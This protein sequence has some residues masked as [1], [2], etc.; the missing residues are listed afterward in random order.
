MFNRDGKDDNNY[1]VEN[2]EFIK[3]YSPT[4]GSLIEKEYNRQKNN[5]EL[6]ASENYCSEAVLAACGSCLSWKYA[7]G[8]PYVRTSG[9]KGRYYGGT[10]FV[11]ELEEYCCNK[12]REVFHTDYHVNVQPHSGSQANFAGY[13]ALINP[14]DTILSLSLD[15]GGHL[16]HGSSVNFS[17]KLYNVIF[18]DVDDKGYIDMEDVRK[19]ALEYK[20]QLIMTG[21]SAY[22]RIID[23]KAFADIAKEVGCYFMVDM[24]HIA[25]LV[26]A[27]EHPSPFGYADIVTTTTHKTLRGPRGGLVFGKQE[28]AKKIDSA[29]FPYAQGGPLEHI[30]AGKAVCAEEALKPEFKEYAHQV[31]LNCAA[32]CDEFIKLGYKVVTGGTD[33]HVFLLDLSEFPFSGRDLQERCDENGITLNKNAIPNDQR[34][35][36]QTSGVRIGTAPMTTRGYKEDDFREVARRIDKIVKEL[37]KEKEAEAK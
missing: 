7:E 25:G 34:S 28:F 13:K 10:E 26:A 14:G 21:A 23:F 5:I 27:G 9:N 31:V 29:V 17:G 8:Y 2:Y 35:P 33:N 32:L 3:K 1:N 18:Y 37:A 11:D 15:N 19:K 20:P 24:A 30:I 12:W 36:M 22:S 6:I 16:T 4:V